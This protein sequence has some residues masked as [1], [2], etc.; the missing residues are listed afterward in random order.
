[1]NRYHN[2]AEDECTKEDYAEMANNV[3]DWHPLSKKPLEERK[4]LA[5]DLGPNWACIL[6]G[7]GDQ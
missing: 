5:K 6:S 3:A 4:K 2:P 7:L 1:M